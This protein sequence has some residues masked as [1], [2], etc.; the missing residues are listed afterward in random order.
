MND[1]NLGACV[2]HQVCMYP[3][4]NMERVTY[5]LHENVKKSVSDRKL[6]TNLWHRIGRIVRNSRAI[7]VPIYDFR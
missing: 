2:Y 1:L 4:S 7:G 6:N 5:Y 3:K